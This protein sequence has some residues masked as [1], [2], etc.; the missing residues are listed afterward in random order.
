MGKVRSL[1]EVVA[2]KSIKFYGR[3][4]TL[5]KASEFLTCELMKALNS[6]SNAT[7]AVDKVYLEWSA[8]MRNSHYYEKG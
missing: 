5:I 1:E 6:P 3:R 2:Q 4:I 8:R 7:V